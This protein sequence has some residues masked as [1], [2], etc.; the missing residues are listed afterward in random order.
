MKLIFSAPLAMLAA[1]SL[2]AATSATIATNATPVDAMTAL[3]GD[4]VI[5]KGSGVEVKRS[6][7]DEVIAAIKA[8]AMAQGQTISQEQLTQFK[9]LALSDLITTQLLLQ[10]AT[11]ADKDKGQKEADDQIAKILN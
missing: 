9:Q 8:K 11:D 5:A 3:F 4:P 10:K 1:A 7:L 2:S 6:Q